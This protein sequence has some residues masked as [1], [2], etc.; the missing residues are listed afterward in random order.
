MGVDSESSETLISP[1]V[2]NGVFF[3]MICG[4]AVTDDITFMQGQLLLQ[5]VEMTPTSHS[6]LWKVF[7][8]KSHSG[9]TLLYFFFFRDAEFQV[10]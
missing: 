9:P 8:L 1:V 2:V 7:G 5:Q 10:V 6:A 4:S 3:L